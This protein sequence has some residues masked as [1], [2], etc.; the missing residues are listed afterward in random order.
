MAGVAKSVDTA[1]AV[2]RG[3]AW[4]VLLVGIIWAG[5][6]VW[7]GFTAVEPWIWSGVVIDQD[8]QSISLGFLAGAAALVWGAAWWAVFTLAGGYAEHLSDKM[9]RSG[10]IG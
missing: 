4:L 5:V 9:R 2:L 8:W 1:G 10:N 7:G 3:V 6:L